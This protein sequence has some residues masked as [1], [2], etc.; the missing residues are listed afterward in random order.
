MQEE[1]NSSKGSQNCDIELRKEEPA[2]RTVKS[3][4]NCHSISVSYRKWKGYYCCMN[5]H[6]TW[7]R[8]VNVIRDIYFYIFPP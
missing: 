1:N 7:I 6:K 5:C 2:L 4:P 3:C 8:Q